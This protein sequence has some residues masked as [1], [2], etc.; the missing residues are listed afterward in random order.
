M[1][2]LCVAQTAPP[3]AVDPFPHVVR[4]LRPSA[5]A[6]GSYHFSDTPTAAY[7]GSGFVV[8]DGNLAVTNH[9][10]IVMIDEAK[11]LDHLRVFFPDGEQVQ[12]R[13]ARVVASDE[14]HDLALL[15]FDGPP[16]RPMTLQT[17]EPMQ[18][19]AI[20]VLGYPMGMALGPTPTVH[21]GVVAVVVDA[22][23]PLPAGARMQ[24]MLERILRDPFKIYQLDLVVFPGH[25]GSPIFDAHT[26]EVLGVINKTLAA[27]TR[28]HLIETPSGI[29]YAVPSLWVEKL[30]D[31][32]SRLSADDAPAHEKQS[33]A[34]AKESE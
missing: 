6:I 9:H 17:G 14:L 31:E 23:R 7:V 3:A 29:A 30:I 12:G 26:G 8:A 24:P 16:A 25:S 19:Q 10:V 33:V 5:V 34:Q 15:Q 18:G 13:V 2:M 11:R 32:A 28:E 21:K 4:Q 1:A 22:V 27:K 20:G